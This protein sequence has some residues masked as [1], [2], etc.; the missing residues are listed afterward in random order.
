MRYFEFLN[1][2]KT[3]IDEDFAIFQRKL[4]F[5]KQEILGVRTPI[6]RKLAK[7]FKEKIVD[8]FTYPDDVY[9]VTFIKLA[10]VSML[11]YE[12]FIKYLK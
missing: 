9:E 6:L 7:Q 2:L 4:I 12:E 3:Y 11:P 5:T 1:L 8:I 10:I